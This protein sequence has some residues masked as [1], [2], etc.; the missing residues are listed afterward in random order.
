MTEKR[1]PSLKQKAHI[2]TLQEGR[3]WKGEKIGAIDFSTEEMGRDITQ[4]YEKGL[5]KIKS[6]ILE[7]L[8]LLNID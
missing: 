5:P 3:F 1:G 4:C 2:C 8:G 6:F 7:N